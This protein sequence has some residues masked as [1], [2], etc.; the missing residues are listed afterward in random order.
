[1]Q[2]GETFGDTHAARSDDAKRGPKRDL[3]ARFGLVEFWIVDPQQK[4]IE[5]SLLTP[6]GY[7]DPLV[8]ASGR[9]VSPTINGLAFDIEP[10]FAELE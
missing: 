7:D 3:C 1:M 10:I 6:K 5:V 8:I 4:Q 2:K 9:L